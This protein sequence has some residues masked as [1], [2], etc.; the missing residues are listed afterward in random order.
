MAD[1]AASLGEFKIPKYKVFWGGDLIG[2]TEDIDLTGVSEK[3]LDKKVGELG[4]IVVDKVY[5]GAEGTVKLMS[6]QFDSDLIRKLK[7]FAA[8]TGAFKL[9]PEQQFY[10]AYANSA[11]LRFHPRELNDTLTTEDI[12]YDH[13]FPIVKLPKLN[14]GSDNY[15]KLEVEFTIFPDQT[16][17]TAAT[18]T[19]DY[20]SWGEES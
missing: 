11:E 8:A 7:P 12:I 3:W 20:G 10:S 6:P 14:E 9:H 15:G 5:L 18:P 4:D 2:F 16:A 17:A 1:H 19:L 13:A